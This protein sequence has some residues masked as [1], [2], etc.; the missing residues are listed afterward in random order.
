[1]HVCSYV[2]FAVFP[3][4][5]AVVPTGSVC[6]DIGMMK[7]AAASQRVSTFGGVQSPSQP[8][9]FR[10]SLLV[11]LRQTWLAGFFSFDEMIFPLKCQCLD[12]IYRWVSNILWFS[13]EK[14]YLVREISRNH[15]RHESQNTVKPAA[16]IHVPVTKGYI[17]VHMSMYNYTIIILII[18][19][20]T[21]SELGHL[22]ER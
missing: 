13:H 20:F 8:C 4:D 11:A 7:A 1:M 14:L 2:L 21:D 12:F 15:P 10:G 6:A 22:T 16:M 9:L 17:I 19:M 3:A 5:S 18:D